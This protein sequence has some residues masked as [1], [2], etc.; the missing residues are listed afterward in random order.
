MPKPDAKVRLAALAGRQHGRVRWSQ[1]AGLGVPGAVISDWVKRGYLHP[2]LPGVYAVG[3]SAPSV[4]GDL[5][6][7]L[8][9]AGPGATLSH[10]TAAWWWG[11]IDRPPRA[12]DVSTPR[13]RRSRGDV[14]V[15][16][17]RECERARHRGL[18]VTTVAQ[19]LLDLAATAP[20]DQVRVALANGEYHRLVRLEEVRRL[21]GRGRPGSAMLRT[22]LT[23][24]QPRLA[25]AR[26]PI[27]V[28][29]LALCEAFGLP[30]PAV[31]AR[32]GGWTVDF[33]WPRQG[34]VVEIDP[35]GNHHTPAQVDRDRR[36]DLAMRARGLR[37]NRYS[38]GQ[39]E[40]AR[41]AIAA[42]LAATLGA[43]PS[44]E[45]A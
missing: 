39:V 38:R 1:I 16:Q 14:T 29:F 4:E 32:V 18:P 5:A 31:N 42:D 21:L 33:F 41:E 11:L 17:R 26:S 27:E 40:A 10:A 25:R 23:R 3:H 30:L 35:Y 12:I 8:L 43:A 28:S 13:R 6:A 22:A 9:Y 37:V 44:A 45:S 2:Q 19:T 34:V 15:H 24:H 7:A 20:L 36:K